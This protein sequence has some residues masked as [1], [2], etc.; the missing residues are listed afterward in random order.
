MQT[1]KLYYEDAY[2]K[3]FEAKVCA[4]EK[5]ENG[6]AVELA[7]TAFF[8]EEG[9]QEADRGT[10]DGVRVLD[11]HEKDGVITHL[12]GGPLP[13]GKTVLGQIDWP[14]RF[15]KMQTHT[16]EHIVS[17]LIHKKYGYDN[18]GFHLAGG[19][20]T[21]DVS[22]E[23]TREQLD[24]IEQEANRAVWQ[25]LPVTARF[26][27]AFELAKMDYRSKLD[28][29]RDV[30]IVTVEGIDMCACCAPHVSSTG[31][32]GV[33][34]LLD[35]MRHR[36]GVRIW[37]KAGSDAL[38]DYRAR[39]GA[40]LTVSGLLNAPQS[41]I[42]AGVE[43]LLAQRDELKRELAGLRRQV[44][45]SQAAAMESTDGN[46]LLF[47]RTDE[48]GMRI[49]ANAGMEKCG[50]VCA[51]FSGQ[52]GAYRFVMSSKTADLRSFIREHGPA[53]KARGGGQSQM[54]SGQCAASRTDL[55]AFFKA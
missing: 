24:E 25:D 6:W 29:E 23:L 54:I 19:G 37:M 46:M 9:G 17:G 4:C 40:A 35:F 44:A 3:V 52:D 26:P 14:D 53:L 55:E 42:A 48:D 11:A 12:T 7:A 36:G 47:T 38:E 30:R 31:Q 1:R 45:E 15:R 50:G 28:L 41:D 20:C 16:G 49:L 22:G 21:I 34:K 27:L 8:P 33:I 13:V 51:V 18:V 2:T 5:V 32:I 39:Y 10:L 43:K